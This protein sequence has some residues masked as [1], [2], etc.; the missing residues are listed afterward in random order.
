MLFFIG[1]EMVHRMSDRTFRGIAGSIHINKNGHVDT[2]MALVD[3]TDPWNGTFERVGVYVAEKGE[4]QIN[5]GVKIS[6]P[7]GDGPVADIPEC[8][9]QVNLNLDFNKHNAELQRADPGTKVTG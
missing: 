1:K 8:G 7:G 4:L 9:F 6:W 2:D 5:P 3:M